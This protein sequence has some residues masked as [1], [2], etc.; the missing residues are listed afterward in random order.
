M[1]ERIP[2]PDELAAVLDAA[3][4]P[5]LATVDPDGTPH[6]SAMWVERD[7]DLIVFN[8]LRGRRKERNLRRDPRVGI[9][10]S[11]PE[12]PY[13]NW[14]IQGRVVELRTPD[15]DEVIDRLAAKYLGVPEFPWRRP[16]DV[17]VTIVVAPTRIAT[18]G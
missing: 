17:R 4:F 2:I 9:S 18:N 3:A 8:T 1:S 14:T 15:G 16:G 6:V 12:D 5:H 7:G 13:R 11:D 10:V